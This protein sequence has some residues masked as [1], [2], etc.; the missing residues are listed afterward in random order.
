MK[1]R[2]EK[3]FLKFRKDKN[4]FYLLR[5]I[6]D[7]ADSHIHYAW[8]RSHFEEKLSEL[9]KKILANN[10]PTHR[11]GSI[12][13]DYPSNESKYSF[14]IIERKNYYRLIMV[15]KKSGLRWII[16]DFVFHIQ[17]S[18]LKEILENLSDSELTHLG[19]VAEDENDRY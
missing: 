14:E 3:A 12:E 4:L 8:Q 9:Y 16:G 2:I 15:H 18:S 7:I 10:N 5:E 13:N 19:K 17:A 1:D 6:G 11:L